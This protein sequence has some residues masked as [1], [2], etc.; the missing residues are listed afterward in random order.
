MGN[1][2]DHHEHRIN[3]VSSNGQKLID[4]GHEDASQF[5]DLIHDLTQRW[6]QLKQAVEHRRKMLLQSEKAQ[7]VSKHN[8][9]HPVNLN[10]ILMFVMVLHSSIKLLVQIKRIKEIKHELFVCIS[11][12]AQYFVVFFFFLLHSLISNTY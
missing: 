12:L 3:L 5:T 11:L 4:E 8:C 6:Q 7:Q 1:E 10:L 2:I 9:P